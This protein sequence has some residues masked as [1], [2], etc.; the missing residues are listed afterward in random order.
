M[1]F[2]KPRNTK[3]LQDGRGTRA[4]Q[5]VPTR[6]YASAPSSLEP[7][8]RAEPGRVAIDETESARA[9][10]LTPA[11]AVTAARSHR[12]T[13]P[14]PGARGHRSGPPRKKPEQDAGA[15]RS[16]PAACGGPR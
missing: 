15:P 9:D 7:R 10:P 16:R 5:D 12:S 4:L 11:A 1:P 14:F 2:L 6:G 8:R 3:V 13:A